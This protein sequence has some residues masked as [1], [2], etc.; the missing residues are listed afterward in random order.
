[1]KPTQKIILIMLSF[2][3]LAI[4]LTALDMI[5]GIGQYIKYNNLDLFQITWLGWLFIMIVLIAIR[6]KVKIT[7]EQK[8]PPRNHIDFK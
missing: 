1:M 4:A 5:T 2:T 3:G 8:Q 7:D 6:E